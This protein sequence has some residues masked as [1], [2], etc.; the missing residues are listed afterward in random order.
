[1]PTPPLAE[2]I[3]ALRGRIE[4]LA[5]TLDDRVGRLME[6]CGTHTMALFRSGIRPMMPPNVRLLSGPGCPVCVTPMGLVDAAIE[7]ATR[8]DVILAT[9]GDMVRVPGS[10][11]SL[12]RAK[13]AGADVRVVYSPLDAL[14]LAEANP[15]RTVVFFAI[16]FETTAPAVAA[17]VLYTHQ[18]GV[19]NL[20]FLVAH[21]LIPPAMEA[22]LLGGDVAVDGFIC[23]GHVSVTTGSAA[24]EPVAERYLVPCVVTGFEAD[25]I[26][27]GIAM[28]LAQVAD[29]RADVEIQYKRWVSREGNRRARERMAEAFDVCDAVWRGLGTIPA[30]GLELRPEFRHLDALERLEVSVPPEVEN[31]GCSCGDVLRGSIQPPRCPLFATTCTPSSPVGPCMVSSEGSCA[32][33]FKYGE[34]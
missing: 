5:R 15:Q 9:F 25:D 13:A 12:E 2:R 8:P 28:L 26:L 23:P 32:A 1:M 24:F 6:V 3:G 18:R 31:P 16:G 17:C 33:F 14:G 21:K 7:L 34:R 22:I 30:S 4:A 29:E 19:S 27:E 11:S 20:L 10:A